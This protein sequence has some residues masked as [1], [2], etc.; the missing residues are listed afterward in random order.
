MKTLGEFWPPP[1]EGTPLLGQSYEE[2]TPVLGGWKLEPA[3]LGT[4]SWTSFLCSVRFEINSKV[5]VSCINCLARQERYWQG[6]I[7]GKGIHGSLNALFTKIKHKGKVSEGHTALMEVLTKCVECSEDHSSPFEVD[8]LERIVKETSGSL[9]FRLSD[10]EVEEVVS[11]KAIVMEGPIMNKV[12]I[13][14]IDGQCQDRDMLKLLS[15]Y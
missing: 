1:S 12:K 4:T 14:S 13:V 10:E 15:I 6:T 3:M 2:S 9:I 8:Q 11:S 7:I 5:E